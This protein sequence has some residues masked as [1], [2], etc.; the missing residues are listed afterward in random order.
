[1]SNRARLKRDVSPKMRKDDEVEVISPD[2]MILD[3][4]ISEL[5]DISEDEVVIS[6]IKQTGRRG[7][8]D[9]EICKKKYLD[10]TD[11]K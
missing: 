1:M 11:K 3:D 2:A 4:R 7:I 8:R 9:M 6:K 10:Y 5:F